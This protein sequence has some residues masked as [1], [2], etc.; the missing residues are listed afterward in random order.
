MINTGQPVAVGV[1]SRMD[2]SEVVAAA[3]TTHL[4]ASTV[5]KESGFSESFLCSEHSVLK[6]VYVNVLLYLCVHTR[7]VEVVGLNH[8]ARDMINIYAVILATYGANVEVGKFQE[9]AFEW[10]IYN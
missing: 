9:L 4:V 10:E 3:A 7:P 6:K 1:T 2:R 8:H 5:T